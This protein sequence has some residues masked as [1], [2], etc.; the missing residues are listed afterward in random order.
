MGNMR[1]WLVSGPA[2]NGKDTVANIIER[3][4]KSMGHRVL[5]THYADLL[6][7]ICRTFLGWDGNKDEAGRDMLQRVGTDVIREQDPDFWVRFVCSV[8]EFFPDAWDHVIIPDARFPNEI[9]MMRNR[10]NVTYLRVERPHFSS[11]LLDRQKLHQSETA[12]D[13]VRPDI[14]IINDGTL[15]ELDHLVTRIVEE[16]IYD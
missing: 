10:F 8:L 5:V 14:R 16:T 3:E 12:L 13:R 4:L 11:C 15:E 7:H 6:K 2:Q 1:V 9:D